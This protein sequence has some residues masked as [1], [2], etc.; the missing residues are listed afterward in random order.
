MN[1]DKELYFLLG[2]AI[3]LFVTNLFLL[4]YAFYGA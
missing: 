4:F 2:F 3:M 1:D